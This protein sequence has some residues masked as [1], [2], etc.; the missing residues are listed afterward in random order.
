METETAGTALTVSSIMGFLWWVC[1]ELHGSDSGTMM[2][3]M[4]YMYWIWS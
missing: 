4:G 1:E 3:I 2:D